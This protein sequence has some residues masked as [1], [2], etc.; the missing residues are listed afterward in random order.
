MEKTIKKASF[1]LLLTALILNFVFLI[2]A[3]YHF[4]Q[5]L[6]TNHFDANTYLVVN[7]RVHRFSMLLAIIINS[8]IGF[9]TFFASTYFRKPLWSVLSIFLMF[10]ILA[11][12]ISPL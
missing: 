8:F 2:Y 3:R 11:L 9:V 7:A 12:L 10:L 4:Q 1:I 6:P 5:E